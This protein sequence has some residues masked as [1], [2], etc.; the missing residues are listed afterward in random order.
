MKGNRAGHVHEDEKRADHD[1][2]GSD[3]SAP[4]AQTL[5]LPEPLR[6]NELSHGKKSVQMRGV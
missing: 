6:L 3:I 4:G 2:D 5:A 1:G